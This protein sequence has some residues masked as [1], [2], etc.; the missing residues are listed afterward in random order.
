MER[1]GFEQGA[2]QSL[3][4]PEP[5]RLILRPDKTLQVQ[6]Q[7]SLLGK[8]FTFRHRKARG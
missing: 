4:D 3:L 6:N 8:I 2:K 5:L 7:H 1:K